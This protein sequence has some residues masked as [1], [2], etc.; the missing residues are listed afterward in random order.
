MT[1]ETEGLLPA[2]PGRLDSLT[3]LR[4]LAAFLVMA[5]HYG[6]VPCSLPWLDSIIRNNFQAVTLFFVLSGFVLTHTYYSQK[7]KSP[8]KNYAILRAARILPAYLLSLAVC[9]PLYWFTGTGPSL[10][11]LFKSAGIAL[12]LLF[13]QSWLPLFD[14]LSLNTPAWSL[15]VEFVMY[16]LFPLL[17]ALRPRSLSSILIILLISIITQTEI[18]RIIWHLP[19]TVTVLGDPHGPV[20]LWN[21]LI[22]LPSF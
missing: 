6:T 8:W 18:R 9:I 16:V 11:P 4:F 10:T 22:H 1:A 12:H 5:G 15:S 3:G 17:L 19:G 14:W 13:L 20:W 2:K 21:P 7:G